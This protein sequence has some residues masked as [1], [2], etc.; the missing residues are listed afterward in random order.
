MLLRRG[1]R[2]RTDR[3]WRTRRRRHG[4]RGGRRHSARPNRLQCPGR[5]IVGGPTPGCSKAVPV[6]PGGP[7]ARRLM[8]ERFERSVR[9][10]I[11]SAVFRSPT[12]SLT[13]AGTYAEMLS[14]LVEPVLLGLAALAL[15]GRVTR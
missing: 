5:R 9:V 7:L 10:V 8:S 3:H 12:Q 6:D 14:R 4:L 2:W 15:R 1:R 13:N 11:N